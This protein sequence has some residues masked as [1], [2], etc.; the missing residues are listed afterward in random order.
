[1]IFKI[2]FKRYTFYTIKKSIIK[3]IKHK[4]ILKFKQRKNYNKTRRKK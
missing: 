3:K 2:V 4:E 1:M